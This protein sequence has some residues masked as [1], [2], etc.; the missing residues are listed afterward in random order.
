MIQSKA[1]L[2]PGRTHSGVMAEAA[3]FLEEPPTLKASNFAD[4]Q[5]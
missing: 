3:D 4:L 2:N 1:E 5:Y